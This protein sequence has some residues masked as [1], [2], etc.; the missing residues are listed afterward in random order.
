MRFGAIK[1]KRGSRFAFIMVPLKDRP[2]REPLPAAVVIPEPVAE[3]VVEP[4]VEPP[5]KRSGN[6]YEDYFKDIFKGAPRQL[7]S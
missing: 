3:P 1:T 7:M 6:I 2:R 5:K 4:V